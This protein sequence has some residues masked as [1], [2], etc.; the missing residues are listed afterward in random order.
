MF[1]AAK[2][3]CSVIYKNNLT[4]ALL[5]S[6][7]TFSSCTDNRLLTE[8]ESIL[9]SPEKKVAIP[10][11]INF[12]REALYLEGISHDTRGQRFLVSSLRFGTIGSVKYNGEYSPLV[13]DTDLVSTIGI[14][15]D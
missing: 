6:L 15:A 2:Q 14:K 8:L 9:K 3:L 13:E 5:I 7:C 12:S 4:T 1:T 11:K 10:D